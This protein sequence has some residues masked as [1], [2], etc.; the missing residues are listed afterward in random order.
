MNQYVFFQNWLPPN[1]QKNPIATSLDK[2]EVIAYNSLAEILEKSPRVS[3]FRSQE[4]QYGL[5]CFFRTTDSKELPTND[6]LS[7]DIHQ[8]SLK[9]RLFSS[10]DLK[11]IDFKI[12]W[13]L[14][15]CCSKW[16]SINGISFLSQILKPSH[17]YWLRDR[18]L[19]SDGTVHMRKD[20]THSLV[21]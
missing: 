11:T 6:G 21:L 18:L 7:H 15:F 17:I 2:L 19:R 10:I 8:V 5:R 20:K 1:S 12:F 14:H 3:W 16:S 4:V 9:W 13:R